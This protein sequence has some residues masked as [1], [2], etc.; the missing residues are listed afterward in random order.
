MDLKHEGLHFLIFYH[1]HQIKILQ[2]K[3]EI[4]FRPLPDEGGFDM[5]G[6]VVM[7]EDIQGE[8]GGN[9]YDTATETF[10]SSVL[11][12]SKVR[13]MRNFHNS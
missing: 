13:G 7:M 8:M 5:N 12:S 3:G 2:L 4:D 6:D 11:V 1:N 10:H 9:D